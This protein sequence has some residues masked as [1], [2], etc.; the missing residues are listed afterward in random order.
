MKIK[1]KGI[2][3]RSYEKDWGRELYFDS[4]DDVLKYINQDWIKSKVS[5]NYFNSLSGDK[6]FYISETKTGYILNVVRVCNG[7]VQH[8][9]FNSNES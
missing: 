7:E 9:L 8:V 2:E 3:I 5:K 1:E 6:E 4:L